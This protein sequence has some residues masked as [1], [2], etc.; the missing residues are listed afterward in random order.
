MFSKTADFGMLY[1]TAAWSNFDTFG[2]KIQ[3]SF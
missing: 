1:H 2:S 3:N